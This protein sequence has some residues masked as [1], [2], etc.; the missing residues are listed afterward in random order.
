MINRGLE[1]ED[2]MKLDL[3]LLV[4]LGRILFSLIFIVGGI[5]HFTNPQTVG[6]AAA[7]GV[8]MPSVLV[9]LAGLLAIAG[10][11]SVLLGYKA[12]VG[13]WLL[14]LFLVPVTLTMHNFWAVTDPQ[15]RMMQMVNFQKNLAMLG[16]AFLITYFGSGPYSLG[17][18]G[19]IG[20]RTFKARVEELRKAA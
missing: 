14:V 12:K 13:A 19:S 5:G 20:N 2:N 1:K 7:Q 16:G 17:G 6:Y 3:K 4:P 10:G 15:M 8:P 18:F 9:P 11:L